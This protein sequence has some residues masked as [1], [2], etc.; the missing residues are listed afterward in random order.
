MIPPNSNKLFIDMDTGKLMYKRLIREEMQKIIIPP[1]Y[2]TYSLKHAVIQKLMKSKM[3]LSKI[4]KVAR[5]A[6]NSTITLKYYSPTTSN[7][8]AIATLIE[9]DIIEPQE[10][11]VEKLITFEKEKFEENMEILDDDIEYEKEYK[12]MFKDEEFK[13]LV[14]KE[15]NEQK[16]KDLK[17]LLRGKCSTIS[18]F[19][20]IILQYY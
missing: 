15:E 11:K 7:E 5:F 16:E 14:K 12:E 18:I 3:E 9:K 17:I 19:A 13:E 4:N 10:E 1:F 6:L 2:T 8:E 20:Q